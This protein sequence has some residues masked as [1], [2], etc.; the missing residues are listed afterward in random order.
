MKSALF[1]ALALTMTNLKDKGYKSPEVKMKSNVELSRS[2]SFE[3]R[4]TIEIN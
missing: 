2:K 1:K 4:V 3:E